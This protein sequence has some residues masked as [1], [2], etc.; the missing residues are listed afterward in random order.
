VVKPDIPAVRHSSIT[1]TERDLGPSVPTI[2]V[3][4]GNTFC[5]RA[6][7]RYKCRDPASSKQNENRLCFGDYPKEQILP[8]PQN[9]NDSICNYRVAR[10][11]HN[12]E[13]HIWSKATVIQNPQP[14]AIRPVGGTDQRHSDEMDH[15]DALSS[16][17]SRAPNRI[18]RTKSA[19][20][21][22]RHGFTEFEIDREG[23][24]MDG[25]GRLRAW[26]RRGRRRGGR[27]PR[28]A[29]GFRPASP[30]RAEASGRI[31]RDLPRVL[32]LSLGCDAMRS[33]LARSGQSERGRRGREVRRAQR[34]VR[35]KKGK[36]MSEQTWH[37]DLVLC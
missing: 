16:R 6:H 31:G 19:H 20:T 26:Q 37:F 25:R 13:Q 29:C 33:S 12:H 30:P 36:E 15:R 1:S 22:K 11:S 34:G 27:A 23:R 28:G 9:K 2:L 14:R 35:R 8:L 21:H 32:P 7:A 18:E 3:R 17:P 10:L 5:T 4:D 24:E